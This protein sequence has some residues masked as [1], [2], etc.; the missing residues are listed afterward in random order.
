MRGMERNKRTLWYAHFLEDRPVL[1]EEG[2]ETSEVSAAWSDPVALRCNISGGAGGW[3]VQPFG[4]FFTDCDRT[5][6]LTGACPL[7]VG[8]RLWIG[9]EPTQHYNYVVTALR[10]GL[11]EYLAAVKEVPCGAS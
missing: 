2:G 1:D 7:R 4:G 9:V 10:D 6:S 11:D 3:A 8:D 5:L